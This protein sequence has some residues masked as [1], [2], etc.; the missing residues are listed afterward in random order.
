MELSAFSNG[1]RDL[2]SGARQ[3]AALRCSSAGC[4]GQASEDGPSGT[5]NEPDI[6]GGVYIAVL[7]LLAL[8]VLV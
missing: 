7:A 6:L 2:I 4:T 5:W 1:T 8:I 3:H